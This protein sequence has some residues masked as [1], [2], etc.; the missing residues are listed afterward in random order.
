MAA[1]RAFQPKL[2]ILQFGTPSLERPYD[3]LSTGSEPIGPA[4]LWSR[5]LL[6]V[7]AM[8]CAMA[9]HP[10]QYDGFNEV[11]YRNLAAGQTVAQAVQSARQTVMTEAPLDFAGFGFS[12]SKR[13]TPLNPASSI[14]RARSFNA[15]SRADRLALNA[16]PPT[17]QRSPAPYGHQAVSYQN[18]FPSASSDSVN[19]GYSDAP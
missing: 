8:V 15:P 11:F 9:M 5:Q 3:K 17:S 18:Q 13:A 4:L 19:D 16:G 1:I 14:L 12:W 2:V 6:E 7:D 10:M